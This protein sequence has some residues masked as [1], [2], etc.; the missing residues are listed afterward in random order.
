MRSFRVGTGKVEAK[1]LAIFGTVE[2][3]LLKDVSGME[4][5]IREDFVEEMRETYNDGLLNNNPAINPDG[6]I[7]LKTNAITFA[8][9]PAFDPQI[10]S[11]NIIDAI[12]AGAAYMGS[13]KEIPQK[14]FVA[15][16]VFFAMHILKDA[17]DKYKNNSLVY[18]NAVGALFIL[19]IEVVP[20]DAEDI[21][22]THLLFTSA[23]VGFKIRNFGDVVFERG[24]N[25]D[26]FRKDRTSYRGYQEVL[27][28]IPSHKLN[29]VMYDTIANILSAIEK[30]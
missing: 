14:V 11:P 1:K 16:D 24:L 25:D 3:K 30:P 22:S 17:D 20:S 2:D 29:G 28:Y 10:S 21:P 4:L 27:S 7:G 5:F 8:P 12:V 6:P 19:G 18:V 23:N 26:D 13:L 15:E 9:T